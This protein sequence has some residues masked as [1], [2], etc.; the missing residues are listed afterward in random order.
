MNSPDDKDPPIYDP[1]HASDLLTQTAIALSIGGTAFLAF[2]L[3][4]FRWP[5]VYAPRTRLQYS[6]PARVGKTF[7]GWVTMVLHVKDYDIMYSVGLDALLVLRLFKMLS[8][9]C[10]M[11]AAIGL[12]ILV[13]LKVIFDETN[14]S[15]VKK[16]GTKWTLY[17]SVTTAA[18]GSEQ[19]LVVHF[20]FAYVFTA[21]VYFYFARFAYQAI[22]LRWHYLLRVRNTRPARSIMVTGIP[23]QL[24]T[25]EDLKQH[26]EKNHLGEV[27]SVEIV[28]RIA[29]VGVLVRKRAQLLNLI[30]DQITVLLGN[31]CPADGYDRE[32][33]LALMTSHEEAER[34]HAVQLIRE[35][36]LPRFREWDLEG[37]IQRIQKLMGPF[38]HVD[39]VIQNMRQQW[40]ATYDGKS[41]R[42]STVGFVTFSDA[43]SAHLAAQTFSYSQPFQ[44]RAQLA[45][46]ARD[47]HWENVTM[48]L[49]SRLIRGAFSLVGYIT[50]LTYWIAMATLLSKMMDPKSLNDHFPS[51]PDLEKNKWLS[52]LFRYNTPVLVLSLMNT[53]VPYILNW[54]AELSGTQSRSAIQMSVLQ[55]Y[56]LFLV[57]IVL[58]TISV[59]Q[60]IFRDYDKWIKNP[61]E[62]P[63]M[64]AESLPKAAPFFMD[65][66][67]LY[68]LGYLPVQLLQLGSIS[69]A[70]FR[71]MVCRTPRQ[72]ADAL[73]PNYIDWSFILPQPM[74]IFVILATYSSLAPFILVLAAMY[75]AIAYLVTKYLAYYVYARQFETAGAMIIPVLK[76]LTGSMWYYYLLIIGL[77]AAKSAF[78]YVLFLIPVLWANAYLITFVSKMFYADGSFVPLDLWN[79]HDEGHL[80]STPHLTESRTEGVSRTNSNVSYTGETSHAT[81]T[82]YLLPRPHVPSPFGAALDALDQESRGSVSRAWESM[83]QRVK[84]VAGIVYSWVYVNPQRTPSV[85]RDLDRSYSINAEDLEQGSGESL[86]GELVQSPRFSVTFQENGGNNTA[87]MRAELMLGRDQRASRIEPDAYTDFSQSPIS[88]LEGVLDE[89]LAVYEHPYLVGNLPTFWLPMKKQAESE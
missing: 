2:C 67:I 35:W 85:F 51:L 14:H 60:T 39:G 36:S 70:V 33:L 82:D 16:D 44:L 84:T 30:E 68:G 57:V 19:P 42:G 4:R 1:A 83:K 72:F 6:A 50:M 65:Y 12:V 18:L 69:L 13:P 34:E 5:S 3:L 45:P 38:H 54:A 55:R 8:A 24:A 10:T 63:K 25:E 11:A 66:I 37:R 23:S 59:S 17:D 81:S 15:G 31:P 58:L 41:E 7:L 79:Q 21:L 9:L 76:V 49:W 78:G 86:S 53:C 77:C 87:T 73:R 27:V 46:E 48:T 22:S 75:Y 89:G 40:F 71:R 64:F 52:S 32:H 74:L 80:G 28:P 26:F 47:I 88:L 62:I 61:S 20:A 29:R 43:A 56:F